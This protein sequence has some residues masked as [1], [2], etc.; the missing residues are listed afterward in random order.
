MSASAEPYRLS[1]SVLVSIDLSMS[2]TMSIPVLLLHVD[3]IVLGKRQ[4]PDLPT[5]H[6]W[7]QLPCRFP[8]CMLHI[9]LPCIND[10]ILIVVLVDGG[11]ETRSPRSRTEP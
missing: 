10:S 6:D 3:P 4:D 1:I 11:I 8:D 9:F 5:L 7:Y 2:V